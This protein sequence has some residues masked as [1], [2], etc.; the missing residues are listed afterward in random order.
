MPATVDSGAVN[1]GPGELTA[2][3]R[4]ENAPVLPGPTRD[5]G[6]RRKPG[7]ALDSI[8]ELDAE[9]G[10]IRV[11]ESVPDHAAQ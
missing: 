1:V 7:P 6:R 5:G 9:V 4:L 8:R 3:P 2:P 11:P 10:F